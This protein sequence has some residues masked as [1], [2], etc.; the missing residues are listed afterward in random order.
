MELGDFPMMRR[1]LLG[2]R[3]QVEAEHRRRTA[4]SADH[5]RLALIRGVHTAAWASIEFCVGYLLWSGATGR[6]DRRAGLAA[7]VVAGECLVFMADGFRCP[8]TGL[9]E[10]AGAPNG[11]VTDIYLPRWLA[12]N[13]P[14]IHLPLLILISWLHRRTLGQSPVSA[15][16]PTP[17]HGRRGSA[18]AG[19]CARSST[20]RA[21][22]HMH[23]HRATGRKG[24]SLSMAGMARARCRVVGHTGDW[25]HPDAECIRV[26]VCKHCGDVAREQE[27]TWSAFRYVAPGRCDQERRCERCRAGLQPLRRGGASRVR[28]GLLS[29]GQ[30]VSPA[31]ARAPPNG[32]TARRPPGHGNGSGPLGRCFSAPGCRWPAVVDAAHHVR[33]LQARVRGLPR[34]V[35]TRRERAVLATGHSVRARTSPGRRCTHRPGGLRS[36][37]PTV[38]V[39]AARAC[40]S[41]CAALLL[42]LP[43]TWREWSP[44]RVRTVQPGARSAGRRDCPYP[45]G[46]RTTRGAA[47]PLTSCAT[48]ETP[49]CM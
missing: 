14:A 6:S 15:R 48:C 17:S 10:A 37:L 21:R 9:A 28:T 24:G 16:L 19:L 22:R 38:R 8:L 26:R 4:R 34:R 23:V 46:S 42:A 39:P 43:A 12:K 45:S 1:M 27:H 41:A 25:S 40:F 49:S 7:A 18:C 35:P 2:I 5:R 3:E 30:G 33:R 44:P 47:S 11:S 13:L 29:P 20:A 31:C 32:H 36:N